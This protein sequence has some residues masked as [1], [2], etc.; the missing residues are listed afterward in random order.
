MK[1]LFLFVL[2]LTVGIMQ[3]AYAANPATDVTAQA[4][5]AW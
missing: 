4:N 2:I 5:A 3:T 1:K